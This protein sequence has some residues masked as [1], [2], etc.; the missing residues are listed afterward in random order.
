[1]LLVVLGA[2]ASFDSID[3]KINPRPFEVLGA[4]GRPPL[5]KDLFNPRQDY[6][7][8]LKDLPK[9]KIVVPE[10]RR[11]LA[12]GEDIEEV[13][14]SINGSVYAGRKEAI[15]SIRYYLRHLLKDTSVKWINNSDGL[16][17][18]HVFV[19]FIRNFT[20]SQEVYIVSF[21]YDEMIEKA[22]EDILDLPFLSLDDYVNDKKYKLIKPH[23]SIGWVQEATMKSSPGSWTHKVIEDIGEINLLEKYRIDSSNV[24]I[25]GYPLISIPILSRAE[26]SCPKQH[27][28]SLEGFLPKVTHLLTIGWRGREQHFISTYLKKLKPVKLGAVS[29]NEASARETVGNLTDVGVKN[30]GSIAYPLNGFSDFVYEE[31]F[32]KSFLGS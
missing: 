9:A 28:K 29:S 20:G 21:N 12:S 22:L 11:R 8:L 27:L 24:P 23:G 26:F 16:T 7:N 1:M 10:I 18:Y 15:S 4:R 14:Q 32:I 6:Q 13:L 25:N 30:S 17:N 19:D 31:R 3:V 2:G 5:S